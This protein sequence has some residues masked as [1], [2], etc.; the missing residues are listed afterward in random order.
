VL[1]RSRV[2]ETLAGR[3]AV[4]RLLPLSEREVD[5]VPGAVLP[6][7]PARTRAHRAA[8]SAAAL[9]RG[10]LRGRYPELVA[11]P[12]RDAL[13]WHAS[14]I[15]T[16]LERDVR[17]LRQV[18]DLSQFQAFLQTLA[19]RSAQLL[20]LTDVAPDLGI[21]VNTAK[22]WLSI[23][24]ATHQVVVL[25]PYF[26]NVGKRLVKMPKIF[27]TDVGTLSY[28]VGLRDPEHA[29]AGPMAGAILE[30]A[31]LSEILK[32]YRHRGLE[33][34][35]HFWRTSRGEEVDFVVEDSE[36]LVP[37]E[38]KLSSTPRPEAASQIAAF[39]RSIGPRAVP[40]YVVHP[41]RMRLP[42]GPDAVALPFA[43]L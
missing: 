4:L 14:Y 39:R 9:W 16:Y 36:R 34:R 35:V 32:T 29:A 26:A 37:I 2:T 27:F 22:A 21:A 38:V 28:L 1:F 40:G 13:R 20:N 41:G 6:W 31:V 25:R 42:L 19:T 18:G 7:E 43:E 5:R 33:P 17:A 15:E 3:A 12:R 11:E 23:L 8:R 10:F 30:T 24:E